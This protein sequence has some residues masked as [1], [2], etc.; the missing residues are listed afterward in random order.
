MKTQ[1]LSTLR[2]GCHPDFTGLRTAV[3]GIGVSNTPLIDY[4]LAHG[5]SVTAC[6]RKTPEQLGERAEQ[7]RSRG[8]DLRCGED[9]LAGLDQD[10]LFRAPGIRFDRP[11]LKEA[12]AR[13]CCLT[14]EMELFF[15]IC[16]AHIIG[17]TGS[18][19]KS[20]TTT[21]IA[22]MLE[23]SGQRVFLGGNIGRP[24]LPEAESMTADDYAVV[25]LSSFQLHTLPLSPEIAVVTNI[26]PNHLDYHRDMAEY[27]EAKTHILRYAGCRRAVLNAANPGS[28]SM[29]AVLPAGCEAL[30]FCDP[31][32][33]GVYEQDGEIYLGSEP[34]MK[35]N[36]ILLPGH[37]NTE[38]YMAAFGALSGIVPPQ[39][40]RT[41]AME[42]GGVEHRLERVRV[43]HGVTYINSSID[44]SPTRTIA[45]LS[46][47]TAPAVVMLGGYDKHIPFEPLAAPLC[48]HARVVVLSGATAPR[49]RDVLQAF[50]SPV[51]PEIVMADSFDAAFAAASAKARPGETVL[52]SPACA[53]FDS[54]PNFEARGKRFRD[55]VHALK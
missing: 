54:F 32:R 5:A 42:F 6:D 24:L 13:G 28:R 20:T 52:L 41:V 22:R 14:S 34:I 53:S 10:L 36:E 47:L 35:A 2:P 4:L 45:A 16:P 9:Y 3:L 15:R 30:F 49:I 37:H 40:M 50:D 18:D 7:L 1:F 12:V 19:G 51:K 38:N 43:L 33:L 25:E 26:S 44:S 17:I 29:A 46:A 21:V 31:D 23:R 55:L 48:A 8:V 39:I 11:E 27:I